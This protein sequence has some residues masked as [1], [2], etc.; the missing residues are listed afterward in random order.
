MLT[1][2][3]KKYDNGVASKYIHEMK[4]GDRLAMKGPIPKFPYKGAFLVLAVELRK[5]IEG[6]AELWVGSVN[7][8]RV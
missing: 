1:L 4:V 3:I 2:L 6:V 8:E 7:S 5:G